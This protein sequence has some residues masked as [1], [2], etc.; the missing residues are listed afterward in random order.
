MKTPMFLACALAVAMGALGTAGAAPRCYPKQRFVVSK[1]EVTDTL[2]NLVWQQEVSTTRMTWVVA[3]TYCP[4]GFRLPTVRELSSLVNLAV[5]SPGPTVDQAAF[6]NTPEASFW[7]STPSAASSSD[8]WAVHFN[9]G[10]SSPIAA[11]TALFVR[12]VR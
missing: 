3:K 11:S 8:A 10:G 7:T 12:C 9:F 5:E 4:P 1:A 2:T 6:P